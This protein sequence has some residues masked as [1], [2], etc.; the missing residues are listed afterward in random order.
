MFETDPTI[1]GVSNWWDITSNAGHSM[2]PAEY[3][4]INLTKKNE[5][6]F[7]TMDT[8]YIEAS[9]PYIVC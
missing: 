6:A 8:F 9:I 4:I 1:Q 2:T 5:K 7:V 3:N